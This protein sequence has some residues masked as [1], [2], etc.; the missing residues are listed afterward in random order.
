MTLW[1]FS[2]LSDSMSQSP[3]PVQYGSG[4]SAGLPLNEMGLIRHSRD[5]KKIKS[6][7]HFREG[8]N[9]LPCLGISKILVRGSK[10]LGSGDRLNDSLKFQPMVELGG[11]AYSQA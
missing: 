9:K 8:L 1:L 5:W 2:N 7:V 10:I 6:F 11:Q 3:A 4:N